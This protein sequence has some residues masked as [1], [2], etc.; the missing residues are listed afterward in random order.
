MNLP[1]ALALVREAAANVSHREP[2]PITPETELEE[3][4]LDS[5]QLLEM[6]TVAEQRLGLRLPDEL[7]GRMRTAGDLCEALMACAQGHRAGTR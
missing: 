4:G 3:L 7:F 5:V 2:H 6:I 1:E